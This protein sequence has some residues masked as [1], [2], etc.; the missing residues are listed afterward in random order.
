MSFLLFHDDDPN[1]II[2]MEAAIDPQERWPQK[3]S[4]NPNA[5]IG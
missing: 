2:R 1:G 5:R 4:E 3:V